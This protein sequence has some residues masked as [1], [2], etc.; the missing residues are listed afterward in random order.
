MAS[1]SKATSKRK[2]AKAKKAKA[3]KAKLHAINTGAVKAGR[4][5]F[6]KQVNK[7]FIQ[8]FDRG[9]RAGAIAIGSASA[10]WVI[11]G[12]LPFKTALKFSPGALIVGK[13][14]SD[15]AQPNLAQTVHNKV[16]NAKGADNKRK[17][18]AKTG[19]GNLLQRALD[20]DIGEYLSGD[21]SDKPKAKSAKVRSVQGELS[22]SA[23]KPGAKTKTKSTKRKAKT[24][25]RA[26]A[27]FKRTRVVN[28][29]TIHE[30]VKN[31]RRKR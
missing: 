30:T 26:G 15:A 4:P 25:K 8:S 3:L 17:I 12:K 27:T 10:G 31:T 7:G 21:Y 2:A 13:L 5:R 18:R 20:F 22:K 24:I 28:G 14:A 11:G 16:Q 23:A 29:K 1:I 19:E 6:D 9:L